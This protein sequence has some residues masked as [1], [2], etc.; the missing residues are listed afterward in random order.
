[1]K[2]FPADTAARPAGSVVGAIGGTP[3]VELPRFA[4]GAARLFAKLEWFNPG[5]S[6]KDR[7]ARAMVD[8]A[9]AR[10]LL[11]PGGT[12]VEATSGNTGVA[13]ALIAASR[14]YRC[15]IVMPEGYGPVKGQLMAAAGA[16]VVRTGADEGIRGAIARADEIA[17]LDSRRLRPEPVSQPGQPPRPLRDHRTRD[18]RAGRPDAIDAWVAGVG[19]TG[20]FTGVARYLG[21]RHP[22]ILRVA[23]EPQG[24]I[25][26]GGEVG[27][28]RGRGHRALPDLADPGP[29]PHRRDHHGARRAGVR[30]LPRRSPGRKA[31]SSAARRE[32]PP[33]RRS[34]SPAGSGRARP[35]SRS[36][37]TGRSGIRSRAFSKGRRVMSPTRLAEPP[38]D[39]S[40]TAPSAGKKPL[41]FSTEC[42]HAGNEPDPST[43]SVTVPIYQTSTYVQE[44]LGKNKGYE[45]GRT[46]NPTR[47]A[48]EENLTASWSAAPARRPSPRAWRRSPRSRRSSSRATTSS[49]RT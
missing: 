44:G 30:D 16:E 34:R 20:T 19:T 4:R 29:Q 49:A 17:A 1:M 3:L 11:K 47:S 22:G 43:G 31:S 46:Q 40:R 38:V 23:V 32:P 41:G 21:E 15:V 39:A 10:G 7:I 25:L 13:L 33:P 42:I 12:I 18:R 48:L 6:V 2:V 28:A 24:S 8:D 37:P 36:S 27:P 9:E 26:T 45:Y 5:G 14:G 35:S